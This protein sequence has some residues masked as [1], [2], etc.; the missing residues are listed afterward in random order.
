MRAGQRGLL[1]RLP[2]SGHCVLAAVCRGAR[3]QGTGARQPG[4]RQSEASSSGQSADST[5]SRKDLRSFRGLQSWMGHKVEGTN[6]AAGR[7]RTTSDQMQ[8]IK[9]QVLEGRPPKLEPCKEADSGPT[10][11]TPGG[12]QWNL[13]GSAVGLS[14]DLLAPPDTQMTV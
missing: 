2:R 10:T 4:P 8:N 12:G 3:P 11:V 13:R 7:A 1:P 9:G 14:G 5:L 6:R